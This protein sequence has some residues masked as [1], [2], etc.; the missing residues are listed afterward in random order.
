[1]RIPPN[2]K[3]AEL[4][5]LGALMIRPDMASQV[6]DILEPEDFYDNKNQIIYSAI[7]SL[8]EENSPIDVLSVSTFLKERNLIKQ[9][10]GKTYL[11]ELINSVPSAA[12]ATYYAEIVRKKK[13]LRDLIGASE[14]ISELGYKEE[15]DIDSLL[16]QA[17]QKIFNIAR[18]SLQKF[19]QLKNL[20]GDTWERIDKQS[21]GEMRGVPTGFDGLDNKLAGL[22]KS[23]LIILAARPSMGKTSLALDIARNAACQHNI[24]VGIFSLE[25]S[26]HQ[27]VD[28]L[29]AAEAYV[30]MWRLRNRQMSAS[31]EDF[32]KISDALAR[33]SKAPIFIDDD[34]SSNIMQMRSKARRLK[35]EHNI[36]LL[37][38]DYLQLMRPRR[39]SDSMV[40]QMTE[41]SRFLKSLARE[42]NIP[43]LALSQLSRAVEQR[44]PPIPRLSDLRDSGS[45]EQDADVCI[46]I[47]R[48]DK[49]KHDSSKQ[50]IAE[51][52]IEKHRNGPTGKTN[53]YFNQE[54]TSFTDIEKDL[55]ASFSKEPTQPEKFSEE[56]IMADTD[57]GNVEF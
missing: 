6:L 4:S 28:R 37:I 15:E 36:E 7:K 1:M 34:P 27:I 8:A 39:D 40:Q 57:D 54:K 53:L 56:L 41:I 26:A 3:E 35:S 16:D 20:L 22:Q 49:Y 23:D 19:S 42:L 48:E 9:A 50:N 31:K 52:R 45:I 30:D 33:L 29:L 46:F 25:M 2:N 32:K 24:P 43:V 47:Y 14:H 44:H 21:S 5:S 10:G 17:Q 13:I 12:N 18:N 11:A 55:A 38:V 51:I